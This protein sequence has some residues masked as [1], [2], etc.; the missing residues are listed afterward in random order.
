[1]HELVLISDVKANDSLAPKGFTKFSSK[2]IQMRLL[3]TKYGVGPS[4]MPF[5]DNDAGVGLCAN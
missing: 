2:S 4:Q 3:H 5:R 1:M